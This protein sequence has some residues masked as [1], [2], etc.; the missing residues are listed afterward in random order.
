MSYARIFMPLG[1]EA[2]G[3]EF[4]GRPPAGRCVVESRGNGGK[5]SLWA[6]DL[7]PE[8]RYG[9]YLMFSS[10]GRYPGVFMGAL[11][12]DAK[13][14]GEA[15]QDIE[16]AILKG[17]LLEDIIGVAVI[18][19]DAPGVASPLCG[20][21]ENPVSWRYGF[22]AVEKE[23]AP[24]KK[25]E[26]I[27]DSDKMPDVSF[28]PKPE[29]VPEPVPTPKPDPTPKTVPVPESELTPEPIPEPIPE[30]VPEPTLKLTPA[31][32]CDQCQAT[33]AL[34]TDRGTPPLATKPPG[35]KPV[36]RRKKAEKPP[37]PCP[38]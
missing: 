28:E 35:G 21:R 26:E 16:T 9:I 24:K 8:T 34:E 20:Y 36:R 19:T 37:E 1:C 15:K 30:P 4:K 17:F 6:Q 2:K 25:P 10:G 13:G 7:K 3:Y 5:L 27:Q 23:P 11:N 31:K 12:V 38:E 29:P 22:Y 14:K 32:P 18:A 33:P